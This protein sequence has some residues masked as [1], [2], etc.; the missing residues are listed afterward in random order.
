LDQRLTL[1]AAVF[2]TDIEG[3]QQFEFYPT[4][5]LQTTIS[6]D[7][8]ELKGF[9]FDFNALLPGEV[10]LFGGYG[11]IDGEVKR[12]AGN[13]AFN[14]NVAP[15]S[16]RNTVN[17]GLTRSFAIGSD[18]ELIPRVEFNRYGSIW[19]DVANT[20]GTERD[21]LELYRARL[22]LKGSDRWEVS[23][24]GDNLTNE[25]YFQEVVPL[26]GVFTV[27]YRGPTRSYGLEARYNF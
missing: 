11:Y 16:S 1:N 3:A 2:Q 12:F 14:G 18:L 24:Y 17:L 8:V 15:G 7:K 10:R 27:N 19:W 6:V 5:G 23:A 4:V 26:L 25:K 21:P 20:P 13:P 22:T 9:D